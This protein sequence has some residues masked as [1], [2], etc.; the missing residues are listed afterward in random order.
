MFYHVCQFKKPFIKISLVYRIIFVKIIYL[1][2][3]EY[4]LKYNI[5]IFSQTFIVILV[6]EKYIIFL[7]NIRINMI[8]Q[9]NTHKYHTHTHTHWRMSMLYLTISTYLCINT[10]WMKKLKFF[11]ASWNSQERR[12]KRKGMSGMLLTRSFQSDSGWQY[13]LENFDKISLPF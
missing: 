6:E 13:F 11:A 8:V 7:P 4:C 3:N 12:E 10:F 2:H 1:C 5:T 9:G